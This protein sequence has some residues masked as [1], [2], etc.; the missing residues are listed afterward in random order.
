LKLWNRNRNI[1]GTNKKA[2]RNPSI[3]GSTVQTY[4]ADSSPSRS[5]Y[6]WNHSVVSMSTSPMCFSQGG[7]QR[8]ESGSLSA[9]LNIAD[10]LCN[11]FPPL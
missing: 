11:D 5:G 10:R 2:N 4:A 6:G 7:N 1:E 8:K 9:T 3:G